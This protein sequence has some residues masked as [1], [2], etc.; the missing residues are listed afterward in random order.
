MK[1]LGKRSL[2]AFCFFLVNTVLLLGIAIIIVFPF[3]FSFIPSHVFNVFFLGENYYLSL[4]S[5]EIAFIII[6]LVLNELRKILKN[7]INSKIFLP[8]NAIY[9]KRVSI[10]SLTIGILLLVKCLV[11]FTF[12]TLIFASFSF[13]ICLFTQ[14]FAGVLIRAIDLYDRS[15]LVV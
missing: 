15:E 6:W 9:L 14:I 10:L 7:I 11:D 13:S 2:A 12:I 1:V 8:E 4:V 3:V 5:L